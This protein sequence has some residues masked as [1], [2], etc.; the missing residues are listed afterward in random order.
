MMTILGAIN[1]IISIIEMMMGID[2]GIAIFP[3]P[4]SGLLFVSCVA[5]D[6]GIVAGNAAI[7]SIGSK[8]EE[9]I[10]NIRQSWRNHG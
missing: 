7:V 2:F 5:A 10:F 8:G 3:F 1:L 4:Y 9:T 6:A